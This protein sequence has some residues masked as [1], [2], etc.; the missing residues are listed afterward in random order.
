MAVRYQYPNA[1]CNYMIQKVNGPPCR[2]DTP[3]YYSGPGEWPKVE[4]DQYAFFDGQDDFWAYAA[5][6]Y[7]TGV[8]RLWWKVNSVSSPSEASLIDGTVTMGSGEAMC[9]AMSM[10]N[11]WEPVK[12]A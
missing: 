2:S 5:K 11:N 6:K 8:Y 12:R 7:P 9:Y 10:D 4:S 1:I 3:G